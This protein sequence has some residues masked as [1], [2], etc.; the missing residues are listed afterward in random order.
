MDLS[1]TRSLHRASA[2][3]SLAALVRGIEQELSITV[4]IGLSYNKF[5]AKIASDL[6]KPRGFSVIGR[7]EARRFLADKPV[8]LL[9]GVG[10]AMRERL[11]RDGITRIGELARVVGEAELVAR[12]GK[13]GRRL[14][15]CAR[16]ED[17]REVNPNRDAKSMS[18]EITLDQDASKL[19]QLSPILWKLAETVARRM[20]NAGV[21]GEG[22]T[23]KLKT[24][25]FRVLTRR[26][27]LQHAT[28]SAQQLFK[29]AE[30]LLAPEIDGRCFRLI[31]IGAQGL[32]DA[33]E[34][35]QGDL[36]VDENPGESK[37]ETVVDVVR[38]RFGDTAIVRARGL[39]VDILRIGPAKED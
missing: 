35:V 32:V 18:S 25:D 1:G 10:K 27:R 37:V 31:G 9:W 13:I 15:M 2:A 20:K 19:G 38:Q 36:F 22:V 23:L 29:A 3:E 4:S 16:G 30:S 11:A 8:G 24:A 5:L 12:Y 17:D 26:R 28:Q 21:A 39:G 14:W 34:I 6:D 7:A 33:N